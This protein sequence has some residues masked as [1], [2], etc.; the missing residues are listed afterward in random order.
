M[1]SPQT[2]QGCCSLLLVFAVV[3]ESSRRSKASVTS[4]GCINVLILAQLND[5]HD[6]NPLQNQLGHTVTTLDLEVI[7]RVIEQ[8]N[9]DVA[10][11][12]NV[13]GCLCEFL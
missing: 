7:L 12:R 4:H 3:T 10:P 9:T 2:H 5:G 13:G 11:E 8:Q 6:G 1:G